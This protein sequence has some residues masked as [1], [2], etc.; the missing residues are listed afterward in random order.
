[1][2]VFRKQ[3]MVCAAVALGTASLLLKLQPRVSMDWQRWP[4]R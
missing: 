1:M 4:P 3:L 2:N